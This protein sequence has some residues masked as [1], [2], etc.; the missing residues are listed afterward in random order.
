[1]NRAGQWATQFHDFSIKKKL[2]ALSGVLLIA[3]VLTNELGGFT[4]SAQLL[5]RQAET[6]GQEVEN[7]LSH[8]QSV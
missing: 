4:V 3:L 6:L 5:S 2:M 7:F 8:I 1:M